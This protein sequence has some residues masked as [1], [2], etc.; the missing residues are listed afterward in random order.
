MDRGAI[1]KEVEGLYR[2]IPLKILRRTPSVFFDKV[3]L[4]LFPR[5]DA[6]D[7]VIHN[8]GA[9]SPGPVG[10]VA[11]PWYM[12]PHQDDNL[13]VLCGT[14]LVDV[15]TRKH[16]VIEQFVVEPNCIT[17]GDK[18][19]FEGP[20]II[21]WPRGVFHRIQSPSQAGSA[22]INLAVHYEGFHIRTN[23]NIYGLDSESGKSR[24]IREGHLDQPVMK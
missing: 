9:C 23:F 15:Y 14:R 16:G 22:A 12:H 20:A 3:P 1:F 5:I 19:L 17:Q 8:S 13:I 10:D 11:H 4:D 7:R 6:I 21:S 24:V 2:I 18:I